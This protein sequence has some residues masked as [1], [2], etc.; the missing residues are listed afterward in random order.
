[1]AASKSWPAWR[2]AGK[3][4]RL[5]VR[6]AIL[7]WSNIEAWQENVTME[8]PRIELGA[9]YMLSMRSTTELHPLQVLDKGKVYR[10]FLCDRAN[11]FS[12]KLAKEDRRSA[13][14]GT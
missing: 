4:G 6:N 8:M 10:V 9:S 2:V 11:V 7:L 14:T 1:M 13:R 12:R 5:D 3:Q